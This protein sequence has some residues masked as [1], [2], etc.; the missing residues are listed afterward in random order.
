M[1]I[2]L[3]IDL[4]TLPLDSRASVVANIVETLVSANIEHARHGRLPSLARSKVR[5]G[6]AIMWS[7]ALGIERAGVGDC[8][9]LSAW[10]I[11][12]LRQAGIDA[13]VHIEVSVLDG[14]DDLHVKVR[15]PSGF[16]DPSVDK[17]MNEYDDRKH[18]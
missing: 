17:G 14:R 2:M 8:K 6:P 18:V 5:Y 4:E 16:E 7:D 10:R 12:E 1:M 15:T 13:R 9:G 11:A 3:A